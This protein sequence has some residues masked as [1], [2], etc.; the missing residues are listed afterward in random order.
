[1]QVQPY[2]SPGGL[3]PPGAAISQ[4]GADPRITVPAGQPPLPPSLFAIF[5][6]EIAKRKALLLVWLI[7]TAAV[8]AALIFKYAKPLYRAEGKL[9]YI[10]NYRS[11]MRPLYN[12]PNIQT[13][14]QIVKTMDAPE[15]VRQ[16]LAPDMSKDEFAKNLRADVSRMSEFLD[17][18]FDSTDPADATRIA[19]A[20]MDEA[21]VSFGKYRQSSIKEKS[22]EVKADY[23]RAMADL[24]R[25]KNDYQKAHGDKGVLD[26]KSE[27]ETARAAVQDEE[28]NLRDARAAEA[29][30]KLELTFLKNRRDTP[31]DGPDRGFDES[32]S[33]Q[34]N[35]LLNEYTRKAQNVQVYEGAKFKLQQLQ[36][37]EERMRLPTQRGVY[38]VSE[39]QKVLFDMRAAEAIVNQHEE[40]KS[41]AD[42][43]Q[44]EIDKLK[45]AMKSGRP[46]RLGSNMEIDKVEKDLSTMP[47]T[48]KD[49]EDRSKDKRTALN[50]LL[51][52]HRDL[53]PKEEEITL[54]RSRVLE[55]SN[56][57]TD[58]QHRGKDPNADDLKVHTLAATG[59]GPYATNIP[60][61]AA[62]VLGV[63]AM[64]FLGYIA[65]FAMP[66]LMAAQPAA[67]GAA[68]LPR[69]VLAMIPV[70]TPAPASQPADVKPTGLSAAPSLAKVPAAQTPPPTAARPTE[71]EIVIPLNQPTPAKP[72]D[73]VN[74]LTQS[75]PAKPILD[76]IIPLDPPIPARPAA[77]KVSP[78]PKASLKLQDLDPAGAQTVTLPP[79]PATAIPVAA[80]LKV[81]AAQPPTHSSQAVMALAER[82]TQEGVDRGS[83]VLFAPTQDQ[84]QLTSLI[85]DLGL[86][87]SQ[88]GNRVLV[89]DARPTAENPAWAGPNTQAVANRVE[90]YLDGRSEATHCFIPTAMKNVEYSRA[91][92]SNRVSGVMSAHRFRQLVEE[93]RERYSLVLMVAPPMALDGNDPLLATLAEGLVIVTESSAP[94]NQ[95]KAYID[96]LA[97]QI[98]APVYGAL[99][100]PKA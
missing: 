47:A 56:Q 33:Q 57:M 27:I 81:P 58:A 14:A 61:M 82:I 96:H 72:V 68:L 70:A 94:P 45:A 37:E 23:E 52:L 73:T 54:V 80:Q 21:I 11:G 84:L 15:A 8:G 41:I 32:L 24:Q 35:I 100:V 76:T 75:K 42:T 91:D 1:M 5:L 19:N 43:M 2:Q 85:G 13:M 95:I 16:K 79:P 71:A 69:A 74:P 53:G 30:L 93:M 62:A 20:V 26:L 59:G 89:F 6:Q 18:S 17:I 25:V 65:F 10:P 28:R 63:S 77:L 22:A 92:L 87:L 88:E 66:R 60:K 97:E 36:Q 90:G 51:E 39:Y 99:S 64:L 31:L 86:Q 38:P 34:L 83:I 7:V 29:K 98:P 48:I 78:L 46:V 4:F 50:S 3:L 44:I 12:P 9:A 49:V 55:L 67:A 40:A